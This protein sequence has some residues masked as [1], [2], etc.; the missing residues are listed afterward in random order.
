MGMELSAVNRWHQ[1][2]LVKLT[3]SVRRGSVRTSVIHLM[4]MA[5]LT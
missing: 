5:Y 3:G 2:A 1:G 4:N